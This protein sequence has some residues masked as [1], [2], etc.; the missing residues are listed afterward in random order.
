M[1]SRASLITPAL[2]DDQTRSD[3]LTSECL[4][5]EYY[6]FAKRPAFHWIILPSEDTERPGMSEFQGTKWSTVTGTRLNSR[7]IGS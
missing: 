3:V 7:S 5:S 2:H 6:T 4:L 1:G